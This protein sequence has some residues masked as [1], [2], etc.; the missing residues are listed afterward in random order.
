MECCLERFFSLK[1]LTQEQL[2]ELYRDARS[3]GKLL[4]EYDKP[5]QKGHGKITMPEEMI[6]ENI[7]P[8][9]GN[10]LVYHENFEGFPDATTV[11]FPMARRPFTTVYIDFDNS[12]LDWFAEKYGL[13]E[14]WQKEGAEEI[15]YPYH[16]SM[17]DGIGRRYDV[18]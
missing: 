2:H 18:N 5:G 10:S 3:V 14:W 4:I 15:H 1:H 7:V 11:V 12:R 6:L 8:S 17:F 16:K 9:D 13:T